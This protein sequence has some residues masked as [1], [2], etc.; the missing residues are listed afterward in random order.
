MSQPSAPPEATRAPWFPGLVAALLA[1][2][3]GGLAWWGFEREDRIAALE[4]T[5]PPQL[6]NDDN[7]R[8]TVRYDP[9]LGLL[10]YSPAELAAV[11]RCEL[12]WSADLLDPHTPEERQLACETLATFMTHINDFAYHRDRHQLSDDG[13]RRMVTAERARLE[14]RIGR[15]LGP[16][17]A[18]GLMDSLVDTTNL[19]ARIERSIQ[20]L[21]PEAVRD[22]TASLQ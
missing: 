10:P 4:A 1:A 19:D 12:D 13:F 22:N 16:E 5:T 9:T 21:S 2:T 18:V 20:A 3:A 8:A 7:A 15:Q 14:A 11:R 6:L 17:V